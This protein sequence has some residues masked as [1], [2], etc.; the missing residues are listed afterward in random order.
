MEPIEKTIKKA[1]F[2]L[3]VKEIKEVCREFKVKISKGNKAALCG[4]SSVTGRLNCFTKT[5]PAPLL[6]FNFQ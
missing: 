1:V 6:T 2:K 3:R 4:R 5:M